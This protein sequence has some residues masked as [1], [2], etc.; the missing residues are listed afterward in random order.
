MPS[1][2]SPPQN[3]GRS[4][5]VSATGMST[6]SGDELSLRHLQ[7]ETRRPCISTGASITVDELRK[8]GHR[9]PCQHSN[10]GNSTVFCTFVTQA[11]VAV[12]QRASQPWPR[13][14]PVGSRR[15]SAQFALWE[16]ASSR[17]SIRRRAQQGHR[18]PGQS[19]VTA[20]TTVFCSVNPKHRSL[21]AKG[22]STTV[23]KTVNTS[24]Y[25][26]RDI[27][28]V[29]EL[30]EENIDHPD[31][32]NNGHVKNR[33]Q[34]L[35]IQKSTR[36]TEEHCGPHKLAA[37]MGSTRGAVPTPSASPTSH[38]FSN[39][40]KCEPCLGRKS[41]RPRR[42]GMSTICSTTAAGLCTGREP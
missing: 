35:D 3:P 6:S 12:Q 37:W 42:A 19:T 25:E 20:D 18:S 5:L 28:P 13:T 40:E 11:P 4:P 31:M 7:R 33:F 10:C 29:D 24:L 16:H 21:D 34:E 14:T 23:S 36:I 38:F 32:H 9:P 27:H 2:T 15:S 17:R 26:H 30:H 39:G 41:G 22:M 1:P 8:Q